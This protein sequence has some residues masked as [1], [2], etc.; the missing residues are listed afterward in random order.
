MTHARCWFLECDHYRD[1][2]VF[3]HSIRC[4][5]HVRSYDERWADAKAQAERQGWFFVGKF[6]C[7][8]PEHA[9]LHAPDH[10]ND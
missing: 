8:C 5:A 10:P 7:Y 2:V 4:H 9:P 6:Y 3:G 1:D